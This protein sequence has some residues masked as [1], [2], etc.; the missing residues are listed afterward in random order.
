MRAGVK[1]AFVVLCRRSWE[2][3]SV[4]AR[5]SNSVPPHLHPNPHSTPL[6]ALA[7]RALQ[8]THAS[9]V[10]AVPLRPAGRGEGA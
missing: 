3:G 7:A 4:I 2:C 10:Q 9:G 1:G 6:P 8:G 5:F